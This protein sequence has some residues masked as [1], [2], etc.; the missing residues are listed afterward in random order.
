MQQNRDAKQNRNLMEALRSAQESLE[1]C[2][3]FYGEANDDAC[4]IIY[5]RIKDM[6]KEQQH[7]VQK[8]IDAHR[9]AGRWEQ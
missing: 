3:A 7:L 2:E 4:R 1:K 9:E 8:E 5:S 6:L